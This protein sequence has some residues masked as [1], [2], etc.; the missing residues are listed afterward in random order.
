MLPLVFVMYTHANNLKMMLR[1]NRLFI[2]LKQMKYSIQALQ[3]A[4]LRVIM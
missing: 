1:Q 4:N 2:F 3:I